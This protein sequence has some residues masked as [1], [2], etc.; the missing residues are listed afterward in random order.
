[1]TPLDRISQLPDE[2]AQLRAALARVT[3]EARAER[4]TNALLL[5]ELARAESAEPVK[6]AADTPENRE[7]CAKIMA[8]WEAEDG[9]P[10]K[11]PDAERLD[12]LE[13]Q[14]SKYEWAVTLDHGCVFVTRNKTSGRPSIRAAIDQARAA[15]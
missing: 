1:M 14:P 10:A 3:A 9:A 7:A 11:H 6:R 5:T 2:N 13:A 12:W 15:K 4:D 8:A